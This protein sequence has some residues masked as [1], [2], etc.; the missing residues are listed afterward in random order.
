MTDFKTQYGPTALI[1][2]G[3]E[4]V[5]AAHARLLAEKGIDLVLVARRQKPLDEVKAELAA[6]F[7]D[8]RIT[9]IS[10]DLTDPDTPAKLAEAT[11]GEEIGML[12]YNAGSNSRNDDFLDIE[13][14][15][16][17]KL[18]ALNALTPMAL[19]HHYGAKM[20]DRGRGGI[21]LVGS[22]AALVGSPKIA[23]YSAAKAFNGTFAE[24]IWFELKQHGVHVLAHQL[25]AVNTPFIQRNFPKA[26]G[27]GENPM[28]L[29]KIAQENIENGP[30]IRAGQGDVFA[31]ML[32][33]AP[34]DFAVTSAYEA[35]K[36]YHE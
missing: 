13:L 33:N 8:C 5:G 10:A 24:A 28:D 34:R 27:M 25:G 35:G 18:A 1:A 20:R 14:E 15:F 11:K 9:T 22:M 12:I 36:A 16:S 21:I 4:G 17:Q 26:Y 6:D 32:A 7:P 19:V 30:L 3:S 29:A 2:G 23:V 31:K